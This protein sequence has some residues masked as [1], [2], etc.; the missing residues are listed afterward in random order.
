[1]KM[2]PVFSNEVERRIFELCA[3]ERVKQVPTLMR[4]ARR[5]KEWVEPFLYRTIRTI[6]SLEWLLGEKEL[7]GSVYPIMPPHSLRTAIKSKPASFFHSSVRNLFLSSH[8]VYEEALRVCTG[9]ENLWIRGFPKEV[10]SYMEGLRLKHL[11]GP[12]G[13]L[14]NIYP[15]THSLFSQMTHIELIQY[16]R[17]A[18]AYDLF[19]KLAVLPTLTHFAFVDKDL[20][21]ACVRLL[22]SSSLSVLIH[23][24][25]DG[26]HPTSLKNDPR[27]VIVGPEN[28]RTDWQRG[29]YLGLDYWARAEE[30]IAQRA[31]K[32]TDGTELGTSLPAS[33]I[34]KDLSCPCELQTLQLPAIL[35]TFNSAI[36]FNFCRTNRICYE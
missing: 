19:A 18:H 25:R 33:P 27:F 29:A 16:V 9:I 4:V 36:S 17:I 14:L 32:V 30:I 28:Y 10:I 2:L 21:P 5:V 20:I 1:M 12:V 3:R 15:P 23:L 11:Y 22:P 35:E 34:A 26:E 6:E 31:T 8:D 24:I 13:T 7:R